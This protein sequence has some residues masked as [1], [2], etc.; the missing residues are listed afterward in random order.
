MNTPI[1]PITARA[2]VVAGTEGTKAPVERS[3]GQELSILR[4]IRLADD[5]EPN[6]QGDAEIF[7]IVSGLGADGK[8]FVKVQDMP[9]LDRDKTDYSPN[10]DL[11]NWAE[12]SAPYV[13]VQLFEDDADTNF[14]E[15][16]VA[17]LKGVTT[18]LAGFPA[19]APYAVISKIGE[20]VLGAMESKWFKNN[21]DYVDSFYVIERGKKYVNHK[22]A[23]GN[24]VVTI[25][26][27]T[28]G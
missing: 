7:A 20:L 5:K 19:T 17:L 23:A 27:Y 8:P 2:S 12:C 26:P 9:W 21:N 25:E 28:V 24:A 4:K 6:I 16:A 15:L 11:V 18:G 10:M 14:K 13:N 1:S 22:G 3:P